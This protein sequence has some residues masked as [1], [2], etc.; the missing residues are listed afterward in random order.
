MQSQRVSVKRIPYRDRRSFNPIE[1][2]LDVEIVVCSQKSHGF[3]SYLFVSSGEEEVIFPAE[4]LREL[5]SESRWNESVLRRYANEIQIGRRAFQSLLDLRAGGRAYIIPGSSV[6]GNVKARLQLTLQPYGGT[7]IACL[8]PARGLRAP[9]PK[10]SHGWRHYGVWKQSL[11]YDRGPPCNV[12]A[13]RNVCVVCNLFGA[14]GLSSIID[15]GTFYMRDGKLIQVGEGSEELFAAEPGSRFHGSISFRGLGL[16]E[17]GLLLIG[18]G[19]WL[20]GERA[21]AIPV[22]L[23]SHKYKGLGERIMGR[24]VY[25][26]NCLK[27]STR[28]SGG[29]VGSGS[30]YEGA[31]LENILAKALNAAYEEYRPYIRQVDEH[32]EAL[33]VMRAG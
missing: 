28:C 12:T 27:T 10:G 14:P 16:H 22:L 18:M 15:F 31:E 21:E 33:R 2:V 5:L 20:S 30:R 23:G 9:P 29:G 3:D 8:Y 6:K 17:L 19:Y 32:R 24:V 11:Q 25:R 1:G 7:A 26:V 13:D 4:R